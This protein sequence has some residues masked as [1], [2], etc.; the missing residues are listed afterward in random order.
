M[1]AKT[2]SQKIVSFFRYWLPVFFT[3]ALIFYFSSLPGSEVPTFH[4]PGSDKLQHFLAFS[5]VG[6]S[7][8]RAL[9]YRVRLTLLRLSLRRALLASW[10]LGSFYGALDEWH[11]VFVPSREVS[12]LDFVADSLGSL[13]G[14]FLAIRYRRWV[15][16]QVK[17][18]KPNAL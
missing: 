15:R 2:F 14:A 4:F 5:L 8:F 11:Q 16:D 17:S 10:L 1:P 13:F 18:A 7:L 3:L 12:Y 9:T 6:F